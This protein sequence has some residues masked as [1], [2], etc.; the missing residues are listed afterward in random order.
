VVASDSVDDDL[1]ELVEVVEAL[2]ERDVGRALVAVAHLASAGYSPQQLAGDLVDHLRQGFLTLVAPDLVAIS[3]TEQDALSSQAE[4]VGLAA[5]VRSLEVLGEA[6]VSMRDAPDPRVTLEVALVRLTHPAADNS[7][8]ALLVRIERLEASDRAAPSPPY[9]ARPPAGPGPVAPDENAD[10]PPAATR[11]TVGAVRRQSAPAPAD[12]PPSTPTKDPVPP[13]PVGDDAGAGSTPF[14]SRDQLVQAWGDHVIGGLRPKAK[15]LFQAG[16]F[17]GVADD[18]AVFG[19]PNEI[20]RTRCEEVRGEIESAL[21]GHFGR[22][23]GLVLIV[24][25]G[26]SAGGDDPVALPSAVAGSPPASAPGPTDPG[27][28]PPRSLTPSPGHA[29]EGA[30]D[31]IEDLSAFEDSELGEIA[32]V[33]NSATSRVLQAFPG[34]EEVG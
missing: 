25:S 12:A 15:A 19:L 2:A 13:P 26:T 20:H 3:D 6:Q 17:V 21:S 31:E 24:D 33:D 16:R 30:A 9:A 10:P 28:S 14:P 4:R 34:A 23:V 1:P 27:A 18:K 29:E 11:R 32:Q 5:L 7:P 22:T 8:E